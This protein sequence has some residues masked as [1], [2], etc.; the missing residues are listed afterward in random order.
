MVI[1]E[2]LVVIIFLWILVIINSKDLFSPSSILCLSYILAIICAIYNID[3]WRINLHYNTFWIIIIGIISFLISSWIYKVCGKLRNKRFI[4][5]KLLYIKVKKYKL[6]ILNFISFVIFFLY[7]IFFI[8]AIGGISAFS[9]LSSAM[10]IYRSKTL[11]QNMTLIPSWINFLTKICRAIAYIYTYILINNVI[12]SKHNADKEKQKNKFSYFFGIIV[13]LPLTL[14]S[15]GRY[16]L[17]VYILYLITIFSILYTI[18]NKKR[19]QPHKILKIGI[20]LFLILIAF[21]SYKGL[22]GRESESTTLDYITEYFG[23]SIQI[24]DIYMQEPHYEAD[25]FGQETFAGIRK[26]LYQF[27]ILDEQG[28]SEDAMEFR[29]I[30]NDKVIGN[31]YTGFRK[32]YHDFG[33]IGVILLQIVQ[34]FIFNRI[35]YNCFYKLE[36]SEISFNI[37]LSGTLVFCLALHSYSEAFYST[38]LSFNYAIFFIM[39]LIIIK[40]LTKIELR[41]K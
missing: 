4:T 37:I 18:E 35:Y 39:I 13:Y 41:W 16:D 22:V 9:N 5:K 36:K 15:G 25:Y 17:I 1:Y 32:P 23:G 33:I 10:A 38:V 34:A 30:Y 26:L 20:A 14:M 2:L 27:K 6:L 24:L 8:K 21:S 11:F 12:I 7:T 28:I 19:L 29:T 40:F 3:N 31:V